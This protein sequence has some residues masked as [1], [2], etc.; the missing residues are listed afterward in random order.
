MDYDKLIADAAAKLNNLVN[1]IIDTF[2]KAGTPVNPMK[3][4]SDITAKAFPEKDGVIQV[5]RSSPE[6]IQDLKKEMGTEGTSVNEPDTKD[7]SVPEQIQGL[8]ELLKG[9]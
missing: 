5:D 4:I 3:I 2:D 9:W 6:Q 8:A 1:D 7:T